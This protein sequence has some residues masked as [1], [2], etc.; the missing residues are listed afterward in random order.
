[1]D[2][3]ENYNH[4]K[5]LHRNHI[6]ALIAVLNKEELK[7]AFP[8][9]AFIPLHWHR[10]VEITLIENGECILQVGNNRMVIKDD[11]TCVNSGV[12][13]SIVGKHIQDDVHV[14]IVVLSYDFIRM[15]C[16]DIENIIFDLTLKENHSDLKE[17]YYRLENLYLNQDQYTYLK[18][19]ACLLEI[20]HL[21]LSQYQRPK[22]QNYKKNF[23]QTK[24]ILS[25]IHEHY[26]EDLT[27]ESTAKYFHMSKEHFSRQFHHCVGKTYLNY[28][29]SYRLYHAYNDVVNSD[30]TIQDIARI[31]GF[32]NTK[33]FIRVFTKE[34]KQ[35]PLQY[36][37]N[38]T[39]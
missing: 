22:F 17:L 13:H 3:I 6:P 36:R 33:S 34:Y 30:K 1:M 38:R 23:E 5:I 39:E 21:L 24:E 37:K 32:L 18:I 27:L 2:I 35:T 31:H 12:L 25:Y 28:L 26:Q 8:A 15:Y 16:P 19:N 10:S 9:Q 20:L 11:F 4:E 7:E 14:I 29:M